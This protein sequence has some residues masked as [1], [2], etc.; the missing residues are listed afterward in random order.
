MI[1]AKKMFTK[2]I[3]LSKLNFYFVTY[4]NNNLRKLIM[5]NVSGMHERESTNENEFL[6]AS[7]TVVNLLRFFDLYLFRLEKQQS[8][9]VFYTQKTKQKHVSRQCD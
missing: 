7:I 8:I 4:I 9:L 2:N 3:F 1:P 6:S 5:K